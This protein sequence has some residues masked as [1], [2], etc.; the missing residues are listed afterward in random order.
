MTHTLLKLPNLRKASSPESLWLGEGATTHGGC[1]Q[2]K[3]RNGREINCPIQEEGSGF[4]NPS[5]SS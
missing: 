4:R 1:H 5:G 3:G 2:E